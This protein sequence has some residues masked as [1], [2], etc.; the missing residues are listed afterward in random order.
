MA[1]HDGIE[2]VALIDGTILITLNDKTFMVLT[3]DQLL[4]LGMTRHRIPNEALASPA[5][6]SIQLA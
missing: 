6:G 5:A 4:Y 3:C 1:N 2:S